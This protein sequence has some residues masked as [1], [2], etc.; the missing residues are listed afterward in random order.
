MGRRKINVAKTSAKLYRGSAR[1]RAKVIRII[2]TSKQS[3]ASSSRCPDPESD[4]EHEGA[5]EPL[6]DV[7]DDEDDNNQAERSRFKEFCEAESDR[8]DEL[9]STGTLADGVA[10][11]Y[12]LKKSVVCGSADGLYR[13]E[14]CHLLSVCLECLEARHSHRPPHAVQLWNVRNA[15]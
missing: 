8:W 15:T 11:H 7:E 1:S 5:V 4:L 13:C 6:D 10:K 3:S 14:K 2:A 9:L 12:S